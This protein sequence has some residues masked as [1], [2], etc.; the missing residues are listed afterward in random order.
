MPSGDGAY[1]SGF[2]V[3]FFGGE[4]CPNDGPYHGEHPYAGRMIEKGYNHG[5]KMFWE[6]RW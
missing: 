5:P 6:S 2:K 3:G 1:I 4:Y